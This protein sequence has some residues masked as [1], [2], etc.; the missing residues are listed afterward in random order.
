M[1][2]KWVKDG[3]PVPPPHKWKQVVVSSTQ[4][5]TGIN[6][7]IETGTYYGDMVSAQIGNFGKII[8]IEINAQFYRDAVCRF[9]KDKNV[10]IIHG[11]SKDVLYGVLEGIGEPC[12]FWL[13]GHYF[14]PEHTPRGESQS[15]VLEELDIILAH[16]YRHVILI[17]DMR[18]FDG[19]YYPSVGQV[20]EKMKGYN[21]LIADDIM[22]LW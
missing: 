6:V 21:Y 7:F 8:S 19:I 9:D 15:P 10:R 13:D 1:V 5:E 17:D 11:N 20:K 4:R 18:L 16:P 14:R 12:I 3:R 22:K 2:E